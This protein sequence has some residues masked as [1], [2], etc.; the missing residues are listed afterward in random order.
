[1]STYQQGKVNAK[2]RKEQAT[3]PNHK[4]KAET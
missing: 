1:M 3:I 2:T 4:K